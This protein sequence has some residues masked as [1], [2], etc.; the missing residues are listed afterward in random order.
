[1]GTGPAPQAAIVYGPWNEPK[2]SMEDAKYGAYLD[3]IADLHA[4]LLDLGMDSGMPFAKAFNVMMDRGRL[5]V[6]RT[7]KKPL[8]SKTRGRPRKA[9]KRTSK[10][11]LVFNTF[12]L[13]GKDTV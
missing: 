10:V 5:S 1:M 12:N 3:M 6:P 2:I 4:K 9:M 7:I 13:G 8:V 11:L